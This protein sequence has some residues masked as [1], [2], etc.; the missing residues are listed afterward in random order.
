VLFDERILVLMEQA[1]AAKRTKEA[2]ARALLESIDGYVLSELG[3]TLP[4]EQREMVFHVPFSRLRG[5]RFDPFFH[6]PLF[7][8]FGASVRQG[9]FQISTFRSLAKKI[10]SGTTPL[11][12]GEAYTTKDLG[13]IP[14]IRSGDINQFNEINFDDVL[15]L[16]PEV[17]R[18]TLK[19][20]QLKQGDLLIAIVGA[21]IGS[22]AVYEDSH[23]ANINQALALV[24]F[25]DNVLPEYAKLV[26]KTSLGVRILDRLKRPVARANINL[27][28]IASIAIPLPPLGVQ[29][30]IAAE[31]QARRERAK[32]LE[33]EGAALLQAAKREV[34][35]MIVGEPLNNILS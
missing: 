13:G 32:V 17:H 4:E 27:D 29:K 34:E 3:I 30:R 22:V 23:E 25:V 24:R 18:T 7:N 16:K 15:Y 11:A 35:R 1:H 31:A 2:E 19:S 12:G 6:Q 9:R 10:T 28:E 26:L 33:Q 8:D 5:G 14:F 21:T 20:S